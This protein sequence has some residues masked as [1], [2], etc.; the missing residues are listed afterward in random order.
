MQF[1]TRYA[2][3]VTLVGHGKRIWGCERDWDLLA[4]HRTLTFTP[5]TSQLRVDGPKLRLKLCNLLSL[6]RL[7]RHF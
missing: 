1:T 2:Q 6:A 5:L 3:N 7:A 4:K